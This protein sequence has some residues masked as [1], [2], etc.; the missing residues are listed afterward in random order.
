[1]EEDKIIIQALN[2]DNFEYQEYISSDQEL[3]ASSD[4]DTVFNEETDYIEFYVYDEN[5]ILIYPLNETLKLT[6][7]DVLKGDIVLTPELD[8]KNLGY[9]NSIY[10]ILYSFYRYRLGSNINLNYYITD[11]SS[12]RTEIRL[13]SNTILNADIINTVREFINYR[14][15]A[16]YF[17]DFYLNFGQNQTIIANNIKIEDEDSDDPTILIKLYEPLPSTFDIKSTLWV[18]EEVSTPQMY[19]VKFPFTPF[20]GISQDYIKGPNFNLNIT[21]QTGESG[22]LYNNNELTKSNV[23]S[24]ARQLQTLLN[25]QEI[26]INVDYERY[27]DFINFS[28][29]TT[30]L[31]NFSYKLNLIEDYTNSITLLSNNITSDTQ[32]TV[33]YKR[34]KKI[35]ENKII[36]IINNFD[37]YDYFLYYNSGSKYSWPKSSSFPPY[38][39]YP[40]NST[41]AINWLGSEDEE[42]INYGG[43]LLSAS[44]YDTN[45]QDYLYYAIP[46]YLRDDTNNNQYMLFVDM[47]AQQYDNTWVY[48]KDLSNKYNADNRLNYGISKDLVADAIKDFGIKLYSNNFNTDDLY[49]AFLG[50]TPSGS[51]FP[52]INMTGSI[53]GEINTPT[54]YEYINTQISASNDIMPL[55]DANKRLYKRL[56]HNLPYLI[57]TKGTVPGLRALITSYGI[58][59]TILRINEF[60]GKDRNNS[61]DWDLQQRVFNYKFD[62]EGTYFI[63][64]SFDPNVNLGNG[65]DSPKTVQLRFKAPGI[66][67]DA[68]VSQS[69]YHL[70][71][72]VSALVLEYTGSGLASGSYSGSIPDPKNKF[73]TLKF[74]PDVNSNENIS[75]SLYLP[76]FDGDWWSV[77]TT[78]NTDNTASLYAANQINKNLGFTGSSIITGF[79]SNY[80]F[81]AEKAFIP[82]GSSNLTV[83]GKSYT[84]F[85]GSLQELRYYNT[86]ILPNVFYDYTMNPFSFEGNGVNSA[87]NEL[88]FRADLGTLLNTGSR[89]SVHPKITGSAPFMTSSFINNSDFYINYGNFSINREYI[90]QD[91][92]LGGIK[93]RVTDKITTNELIMPEGNT[94]S[95]IRSLQQLSFE[96]ASYTPNV[97]YMEVAFSPQ[98]Q[99]NDDINSQMGYFNLG[100]YIGDPRQISESGYNYPNLDTLR[101]AYFE[102]YISGYDLNDFIRLMKFFDNSLFKMI[103]D[104]TPANTSLT[105]GVVIKQHL[106]ERNRVRPP[107]VSWINSAYSG[108]LKPQVRD[109]STGSG[110]TGAYEFVSGSS[111]YRFSGGTGGSLQQY[112]GLNTSPSASAY[113]LSNI[114]SLTQSFSESLEG[115]LGREVKIIFNQDE[116]YNGEFSGSEFIATT[117]SLSPDCIPYHKSPDA[118]LNYY[119]LF[120]SDSTSDIFYGTTTLEFWQDNR[121]EPLP[122]YVWIFTQR[123]PSTQEYEATKIKLAARDYYGNEVRDY[124]LGVEFVQFIFPEGFK[125]YFIEGV[126]IN[127]NSALLN[128]D[129]QRGDYRFVSSSNGGTENWSLR[130]S[131]DVSS[132]ANPSVAGFDPNSQNF[133]HALTNVQLQAI[134]YYNNV[135]NDAL[136]FFDTGSIDYLT[137]GILGNQEAYDWGVYTIPRT[138]NVPWILSASIAYSSSGGNTV[139]D[140]ISSVGIYHSGSSVTSNLGVTTIGINPYDPSESRTT[141]SFRLPPISINLD[142]SFFNTNISNAAFGDQIHPFRLPYTFSTDTTFGNS[143]FKEIAFNNS[144]INLATRMYISLTTN[145]G[146]SYLNRTNTF[147]NA[148]SFTLFNANDINNTITVSN[149][150]T[151]LNGSGVIFADSGNQWM[152]KEFSAGNAVG[153]GNQFTDLTPIEFL[154]S[155]I[156]DASGH[157]LITQAGT[158]SFDYDFSEFTVGG[159]AANP[160]RAKAANIN[161]LEGTGSP[162]PPGYTNPNFSSIENYSFFTTSISDGKIKAKIDYAGLRNYI[163]DAGG[164]PSSAVVYMEYSVTA[165]Q[166]TPTPIDGQPGQPTIPLANSVTVFQGE[167]SFAGSI[168]SG[169]SEIVGSR[170]TFTINNTPENK[171]RGNIQNNVGPQAS[172]PTNLG[173]RFYEL[174]FTGYGQTFEYF[175]P[176]FTFQL[177]YQS[178]IG[179]TSGGNTS[180][181]TA[182]E[183]V[184]NSSTTS[185]SS[186]PTTINLGSISQGSNSSRSRILYGL[187]RSIN[188]LN[189]NLQQRLWVTGSQH[190]PRQLITSSLYVKNANIDPEQVI[191]FPDSPINN[192]YRTSSY[193]EDRYSVTG[194]GAVTF[195]YTDALTN[196]LKSKTLS[197]EEIV[198]VNVRNGGTTPTQTSGGSISSTLEESNTLYPTINTTESMYFVETYIT[199]TSYPNFTPIFGVYPN[200]LFQPGTNLNYPQLFITNSIQDPESGYRFTG[201]LQI[202]KGNADNINSLGVPVFSRDFIVPNSESIQDIELSG[203]F[204]SNFKYNDTF[205]IAIQ[206]DKNLGSFLDITEYSMSIFPS[207]SKFGSILDDPSDY[208]S[209]IY[210]DDA[211]GGSSAILTPGYGK[212]SVP[213]LT[214]TIVPNFYSDGVLPFALAINCQPLINNFNLQRQSTYLMDVDYTNQLGTLIPVNQAQILSGSA[215]RATVPD[216]NYTQHTW[217][218][219]RYDGS[220]AQSKFLNVWSPTDFGTYGQLPV[221]ELRNAYFGY[222]SSIKDPYPIKNDVTRLNMSYLVDGQSNALPPSLQGVAKD[223]V[224]KTFPVGKTTKLAIDIK[225]DA[226]VLEEINDE[227]KIISVGTYLAPVLYSQTSS[228]GYSSG[229]PLSGSG[230]I[231]LYD[232]PDTGF[233]DYSFV[234]EGTSSAETGR[235]VSFYSQPSSNYTTGSYA[236]KAYLLNTEP[237]GAVAFVSESFRSS[238]QDTSQQQYL[239][240]IQAVPT[241]YI[242]SADYHRKG[243]WK[244]KTKRR[245]YIEFTTKLGLEYTYDGVTTNIPFNATDIRLRVWKGNQP[246]D[247]GS[248][249]DKVDFVGS[250]VVTR[251]SG[252]SFWSK[253]TST[254]SYS[255]SSGLKLDRDNKLNMQVDEAIVESILNSR[256]LGGKGVEDGGAIQGLEWVFYANSGENIYKKDSYIRWKV[257]ADILSGNNNKNTINPVGFPGPSFAS[258]LSLIG[259]KTHLLENENTASAPYW[260]FAN[261]LPP[262][263]VP[264][265]DTST[266]YL[267]MSASLINEAYGGD[268]SQ[269]ELPYNPGPYIGFPGNQEPKSSKIGEVVSSV[270]IQENDEIRFGNNENYSYKI[271]KVWAPQ[272]NV[273]DDD[274][275]RVKIELDRPLPGSDATNGGASALNKDFFLL[276]RYVPNA[277]SVFLE[278]PYPYS[279][280]TVSASFEETQTPNGQLLRN[281]QELLGSII[282]QPTASPVGSYTNVPLS[283]SAGFSTQTGEGALA[284]IIVSGSGG[285]S[286]GIISYIEITNAGSGYSI[287]DSL[288]LDNST[289]NPNDDCLIRLTPLDIGRTTTLVQDNIPTEF[290]SPGIMFPEFPSVQVETSAS[291][292]INELISKGVIDN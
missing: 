33:S 274:I 215:Q 222:F 236:E 153:V 137:T 55:D 159:V 237:E 134:R 69:I 221:I 140:D 240:T 156:N 177:Y 200:T 54:G 276:R 63:S 85:S 1:M 43:Q 91:Q 132:S 149:A 233:T 151:V 6:S 184:G 127:P 42:S 9:D 163:S 27:S 46:E 97:D 148:N 122:G 162:I 77:Q 194:S 79:D 84:L 125:K 265:T 238:G 247:A 22:Q 167:E 242:Y 224:E 88:I 146:D 21:Q 287:N 278:M 92:V 121:N 138:P 73:G 2:P 52:F 126:T 217:T 174:G 35:Y 279:L 213:V 220:K 23:T 11:I 241:T 57:K 271:V 218:D 93:N 152:I 37:G 176:S 188:Q 61:Q 209:A 67:L 51:A 116:F 24:S 161:P 154:P 261:D 195:Q 253:S 117:Q 277:N 280:S 232:N 40:S 185:P 147:N 103:K 164:V 31:K 288:T 59:D 258:K 273:M 66:P 17:V 144:S 108:T 252:G 143:N 275:G 216:S 58:P 32:N 50:I 291:V 172:D 281:P 180:G 211:Y 243:N 95:G 234:A 60:G 202:Y 81:N 105:S 226:Q 131:G 225:A 182:V 38:E 227:H 123:N 283:S 133:F 104:F 228:R 207:E 47:V 268:F 65:Y 201:S 139:I 94:L 205:R 80:Y 48:T 158:A 3:I 179:G 284:T 282:T 262:S 5:N 235:S 109:Y 255:V 30:R 187:A 136:G 76:F 189:G 15:E 8:L 101:D 29:A 270:F 36:E 170:S 251:R 289:I 157:A 114:Y 113:G 86:E 111:I 130:V 175:I 285:D 204:I 90:H 20:S 26:S 219:I 230:R 7:Y 99:I 120:F 257:E 135:Y 141:G 107:Q 49:T 178:N 160:P 246:Y 44:N 62:T 71:N 106:L 259:S 193:I 244:R 223:I 115:R 12:D 250:S 165:T 68:S 10:S 229:I 87:P 100:D 14:E 263:A 173:K 198:Y 272:E 102:K 4:L 150:S 214:P 192:I 45:N 145:D 286:E 260:V 267:Y 248:V 28:S 16:G 269:G 197:D 168:L 128:V 112:A 212:Y 166:H 264:S 19:Q 53:G 256:G 74:I 190:N 119:P 25:K 171:S 239:S 196:S 75:A 13:D 56:Y 142:S 210:G 39:L 203:S 96:S 155:T 208:G 124:L 254:T 89:I 41:E 169:P 249:V 98:D 82:K 183:G 78:V 118:P 70:E 64:S 181:A 18:V 129:T 186:Q 83:G 266:K 110:D 231:S 191:T 199:G 206:A 245:E 72:S 292:I 34:S 290:T